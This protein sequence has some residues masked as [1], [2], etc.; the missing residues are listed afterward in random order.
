MALTRY[1]H[2]SI[3]M[4]PEFQ[5]R[6][7]QALSALNTVAGAKQFIAIMLLTISLPVLAALDIAGVKFDD[8]AI[9]GAG[10]TVLNGAGLRRILLFKAYAIG[11]YLPHHDTSLEQVLADHGPKRLRIVLLRDLE[12]ERISTTIDAGLHRNLSDAE[13]APLGDRVDMLR[14]AIHETGKAR[15]GAVIHLD[16]LP[17]VKTGVTRLSIDGVR[18]GQ[19]IP[20]EDFYHALLKVWLGPN[21][22]DPPLRDMLLGREHS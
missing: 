14:R 21:V 2:G 22:N 15:A 6:L 7:T 1:T 12:A 13:F 8:K 11:L 10:E 5:C 3:Q 19:D 20:G 4:K 17:G 16:W 9:V 18:R